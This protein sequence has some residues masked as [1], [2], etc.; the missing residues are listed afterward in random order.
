MT[1]VRTPA[2]TQQDRLSRDSVQ[3]S[4]NHFAQCPMPE[5]KPLWAAPVPRGGRTLIAD[6]ACL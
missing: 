6:G 4:K 1:L 5:A 2:P 3:C